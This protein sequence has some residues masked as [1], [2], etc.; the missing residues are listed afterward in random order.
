MSK[1]K[2]LGILEMVFWSSFIHSQEMVHFGKHSKTSH[3][4]TL[5]QGGEQL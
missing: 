5:I 3:R 1:S 2:D 4:W